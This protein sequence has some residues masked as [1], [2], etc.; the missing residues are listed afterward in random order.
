MGP[1]LA[2]IGVKSAAS[3]GLRGRGLEQEK[4]DYSSYTFVTPLHPD[5]AVQLFTRR[6]LPCF[7]T[8]FHGVLF[9]ISLPFWRC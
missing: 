6:V 9:D 2:E 1:A 3:G 4:G 8:Y 7:N 5:M